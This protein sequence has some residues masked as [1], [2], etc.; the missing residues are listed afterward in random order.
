MLQLRGT[1]STYSLKTT[2]ATSAGEFQIQKFL[3]FLDVVPPQKNT[4]K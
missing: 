2:P 1:S 3:I 4:I